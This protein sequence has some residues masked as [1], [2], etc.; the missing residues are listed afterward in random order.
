MPSLFSPSRFL[1]LLAV[2]LLV[3]SGCEKDEIRS[4][5]V[6]RPAPQ[7]LAANVRLLVAIFDHGKDKWFF[8]LVGPIDE[9]NQYADRF[10]TFAESVRFTDKVDDPVEWKT[11]AG[12][13][14]KKGKE[15]LRYG[16]LSM[17]EEGKAPLVTVF[18][19]D[20]TSSL[21]DNVN[22]WCRLDL[23]RPH[24]REDQLTQYTKTIHSGDTRGILVDMTGPGPR[25]KNPHMA[26]MR[27][28]GPLPITY[29]TPAGWKELGPQVRED[30]RIFSVF[31]VEGDPKAAAEITQMPT[32]GS[33]L[34][35]VNRWR[36]KVGLPPLTREQLDKDPPKKITVAG[37][38]CP[39]YDFAGRDER[40][41][42]VVVTRGTQSWY[43][44]L[45]GSP[46]IVEKNES[47]FTSFVQSVKFTGAADE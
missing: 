18:R 2:G 25:G 38:P 45:I 17:G 27:M 41:L 22:R 36:R 12:W 1:C 4:Y 23:G 6:P 16:E 28:P 35:H 32:V 14:W 34:L 42:V 9:V 20:Q 37:S 30:V 10:Q 44:R 19:F 11:P 33:P 13:N 24:L 29:T 39:F 21:L 15:G 3:V 47:R 43:F 8:K 40:L 31:E 5:T 26:E 7:T 46:A